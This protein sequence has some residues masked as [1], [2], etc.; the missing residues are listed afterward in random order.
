MSVT[1]VSNIQISNEVI[2]TIVNVAAT[3]V[4]GVH[5]LTSSFSDNIKDIIY[6]KGTSKGVNVDVNENS[7]VTVT[8]NLVVKYNYKIQE[9]ALNVQN[10]VVHAISDMTNFNVAAVNINVVGVNI[11]KPETTK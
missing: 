6:K 4:D 1:D 10:Q 8:L 3:E 11:P 5:S 2:A 7:D 9:V